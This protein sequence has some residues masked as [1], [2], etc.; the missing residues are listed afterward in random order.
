MKTG[1]V[2]KVEVLQTMPEGLMWCQY[3]GNKREAFKFHPG[4]VELGRVLQVRISA[5]HYMEG[6]SYDISYIEALTEPTVKLIEM[7]ELS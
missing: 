3:E 5:I 1:D 2:I 6:S 4:G 7:E